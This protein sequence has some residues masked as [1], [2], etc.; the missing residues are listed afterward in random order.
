MRPD[1]STKPLPELSMGRPLQFKFVRD[2]PNYRL[3][4]AYDA[5]VEAERNLWLPAGL[6]AV[7]E[8]TAFVGKGDVRH[9]GVYADGVKVRCCE[10]D[11]D[12]DGNCDIHSAPGV[13]RE[14]Y[15]KSTSTGRIRFVPVDARTY[16]TISVDMREMERKILEGNLVHH[17]P[18][19]YRNLYSPESQRD[20]ILDLRR[21]MERTEG[22]VNILWKAVDKLIKRLIL[23]IKG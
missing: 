23:K 4:S 15:K 13:L 3:Y 14:L 2:T 21:R 5:E 17:R 19:S 10:R 16:E 12:G 18:F 20:A 6:T 11:S 9:M 1:Y 8:F 22:R 7:P